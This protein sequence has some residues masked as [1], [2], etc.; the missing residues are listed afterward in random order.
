[1]DLAGLIGE[2]TLKQR[3]LLLCALATFVF[4]QIL[5]RVYG[6]VP[7]Y[8]GEIV[9]AKAVN[10]LTFWT[11]TNY[12]GY[13]RYSPFSTLLIS[14]LDLRII[15]PLFGVVP[16]NKASPYASYFLQPMIILFACIAFL[17]FRFLKFFGASDFPAFLGALFVGI[18]KGFAYYLGFVA[19][20]SYLLLMIA[21]FV[22]ICGL[23]KYMN[24]GQRRHA[25]TYVVAMI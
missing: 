10:W 15:R 22:C 20:F 17:M 8:A 2:L 16:I 12:G 14:V 9:A 23:I 11:Q 25:F 6:K 19:T 18:H 3:N 4:W 21:S 1:M 5:G 13:D 24:E 7:L